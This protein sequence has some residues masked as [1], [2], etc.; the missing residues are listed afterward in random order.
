MATE[1]VIP[2]VNEKNA[3]A[4]ERSLKIALVLSVLAH[5]VLGAYLSHWQPQQKPL[6]PTETKIQLKLT[7]S[8]LPQQVKPEMTR[9]P[10]F[11]PAS[12]PTLINPVNQPVAATAPVAR[13]RGPAP[14]ITPVQT[15]AASGPTQVEKVE[16]S[17]AP[18]ARA[19]SADV[20]AA[21]LARLEQRKEYPYIARKRGQTGTVTVQIRIAPDGALRE[22]TVVA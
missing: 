13:K 14:E 10:Q 3:T 8:P 20:I 4:R 11:S 9:V 2:Y 21:F 1:N 19:N 5:G 15:I 18:A 7:N 6:P 16:A 22:S 12:Q 17:P